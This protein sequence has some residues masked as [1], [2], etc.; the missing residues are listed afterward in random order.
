MAKKSSNKT[1]ESSKQAHNAKK[2][3]SVKNRTICSNLDISNTSETPKIL[4]NYDDLS[5][6]YINLLL[7]ESGKKHSSVKN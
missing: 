5:N 1:I 7:K 4:K 6:L 3:E 2:T